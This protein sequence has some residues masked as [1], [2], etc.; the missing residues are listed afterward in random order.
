MSHWMTIKLDDDEDDV[1]LGR[2]VAEYS[3]KINKLRAALLWIG[4]HSKDPQV[5]ERVLRE[6]EAP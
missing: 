4:K 5:V 6:L 2:L 3:E 1:L